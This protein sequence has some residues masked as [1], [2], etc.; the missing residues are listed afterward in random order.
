MKDLLHTGVADKGGKR[1]ACAVTAPPAT[2]IPASLA[3]ARLL[4]S[5][6][7]RRSWKPAMMDPD[8]EVPRALLTT[9]LEA[10]C[11]A[12]THGLT[13]PWRFLII[14]GEAR[15]RLATHLPA[16]YDLVTPA[17]QHRPEKRAKLTTLFHQAPP[18]SSP[19]TT[20]PTAKS[21][22]SKINWPSP[23]L[24]KTSTSPPTPRA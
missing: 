16:V 15:Q 10:A 9:L 5:L 3:K 12:P 14:T 20:P 8:R 17:A 1:N 7:D 6:Q 19:A 24:C 21:R 4:A 18:S 2:E 23:A 13:E 22:C 11:L